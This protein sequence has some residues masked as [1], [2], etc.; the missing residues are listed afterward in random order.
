M[1][2]DAPSAK[3]FVDDGVCACTRE[4]C[5]KGCRGDFIECGS[6]RNACDGCD[7]QSRYLARH[8]RLGHRYA[9]PLQSDK[10]EG[11]K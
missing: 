5:V 6:N 10:N 8:G 7:C 2:A 4:Y 3:A 11:A 9:S 1:P